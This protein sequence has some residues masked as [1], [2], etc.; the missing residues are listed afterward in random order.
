MNVIYIVNKRLSDVVINVPPAQC[1]GSG[2]QQ[3]IERFNN[4]YQNIKKNDCTSNSGSCDIQGQMSSDNTNSQNTQVLRQG[5]LT[6]SQ[7]HRRFHVVNKNRHCQSEQN[8]QT[9]IDQEIPVRI[10]R[11]NNKFISANGDYVD[12]NVNF[13]V[14][15]S[16]LEGSPIKGSNF[17][18]VKYS[19][20]ADIDQIGSIPVNN[21]NGEPLAHEA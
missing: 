19:S 1:S 8:N 17:G 9:V 7:N 18:E 20:H 3:N 13:I 14:P 5:Y 11:V 12:Q 2:N 15:M 10:N 6:D 21:Y 4:S 16:Y